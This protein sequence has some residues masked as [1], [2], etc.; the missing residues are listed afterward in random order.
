VRRVEFANL[1]ETPGGEMAIGR[2]K[3]TWRG[4]G[5]AARP[6]SSTSSRS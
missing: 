4:L 3:A 1:Y 6:R 5:V 2:L